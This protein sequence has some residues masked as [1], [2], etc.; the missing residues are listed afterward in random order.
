VHTLSFALF[1]FF[2]FFFSCLV[3][4]FA[5]GCGVLSVLAYCVWY[6]DLRECGSALS[7]FHG[8]PSILFTTSND[9]LPYCNNP[10][11]SCAIVRKNDLRSALFHTVHSTII[12]C[13]VLRQDAPTG[14]LEQGKIQIIKI[15]NY[16]HRS[17]PETK[18]PLSTP[19]DNPTECRP[20][21]PN[22]LFLPAYPIVVSHPFSIMTS[23]Q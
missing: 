8:C 11:N 14:T 3:F 7:D 2:F 6:V 12:S 19:L 22:Q 21:I 10:R 13:H 17:F 5:F 20:N 1:L 4:P 18:T 16:I 9:N 15:L 23:I